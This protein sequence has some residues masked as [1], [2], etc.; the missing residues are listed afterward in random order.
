MGS[1]KILQ[2]VSRPK[3]EPGWLQNTN[4]DSHPSANLLY[5]YLF[6]AWLNVCRFLLLVFDCNIFIDCCV[7]TNLILNSCSQIR[8]SAHMEHPWMFRSLHQGLQL[9]ILTYE[10]SIL[11]NNPITD[12]TNNEYEAT[13]FNN[14]GKQTFSIFTVAPC[15]LIYVF[16][17]PTNVLLLI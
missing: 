1:Y 5:M 3:L 8:M 11:H 14:P 9:N 4:N 17:S 2:Q 6:L 7:W 15:I 12:T 13:S 16:Y 10:T